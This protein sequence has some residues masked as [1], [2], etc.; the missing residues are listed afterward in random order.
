VF[1]FTR[2]A[3]AKK[4]QLVEL[5]KK[6]VVTRQCDLEASAAELA[7]ALKDIDIVVSS[8]GPSDQLSQINLATAAKAA[9]VKRFIP[10]AFITVCAPGG[11]MWLRDEVGVFSC[12]FCGYC[13]ALS[14]TNAERKSVQPRQAIE[15]ALHHH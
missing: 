12:V 9:G 5:E 15:T 8:V 10:C 11:I 13:P 6:G 4:P 14:R 1:A 2:P 7:E 3:S